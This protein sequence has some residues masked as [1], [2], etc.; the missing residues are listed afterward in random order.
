MDLRKLEI[1]VQVAH[2]KNFSRAAEQ[3][4]MAQP[5]V[6]IAV[7]KLEEEL[8]ATLF[9]RD[10][11]DLR[12]TVEGQRVL[13]QAEQILRQVDELAASVGELQ[14]VLRG[15]IKLA[16]PAMAGTY[17]LPKL[18]GQFLDLH[19]GLT[20]SVTQAGTQK[21]EQMLL[22]DR[23]EL[24]VVTNAE[25]NVALEV[26]PLVSEKMMLCVGEGNALRH[27]KQVTVSELSHQSMVLY[28]SDY[29]IRQQFNQLCAEQ[30]VEPDIRLQTNYLPLLMQLVKQNHGAT[31]G[32][33]MMAAQES[34]IFAVPLS[35]AVRVN[36]GIA[37]RRG[38]SISKAHQAFVEWLAAKAH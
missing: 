15:E 6:S 17:F 10:R 25:D 11:R 29:F 32:L 13:A 38:R 5:P 19:P 33:A 18:L 3:L 30:R 8:G 7:R 34:G 31:I 12:L 26:V 16:C 23:I 20:A 21:I 37:V 27:K 1:F 22:D 36:L 35:P 28:E 4:H 9:I 14:G 24:G 2:L